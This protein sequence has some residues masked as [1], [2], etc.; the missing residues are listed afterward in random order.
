MNVLYA[1]F[2]HICDLTFP[3]IVF[4]H[5][6]SVLHSIS[7]VILFL[8][9]R[10]LSCVFFPSRPMCSFGL[11][12]NISTH[13]QPLQWV[14]LCQQIRV[15]QMTTLYLSYSKTCMLGAL[16][17]VPLTKALA[18]ELELVPRRCTVAAHCS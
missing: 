17:Q 11:S 2:H 5:N 13:C 6:N 14:C 12:T 1:L 4:P 8:L 16:L 3:P 7:Y 9:D 10:Y 18:S 15:S